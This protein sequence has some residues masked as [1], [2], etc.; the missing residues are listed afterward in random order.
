MIDYRPAKV[1][2]AILTAF[3][4][5]LFVTLTAVRNQRTMAEINAYREMSQ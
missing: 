1:A 3:V 2:L 4:A 5:V